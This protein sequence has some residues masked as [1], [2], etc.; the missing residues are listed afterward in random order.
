MSSETATF[1]PTSIHVTTLGRSRGLTSNQVHNCTHDQFG[2]LWLAGP[3][4]LN[5]FDGQSVQTIDATNGL[6]CQGLRHVHV[7]E[8]GFVW[9]GTDR[10]LECISVT[11]TPIELRYDFDW[12]FG[13]VQAICTQANT[14]WLGTANG[15]LELEFSTANRQLSLRQHHDIG[16]VKRVL[17]MSSQRLLVLSTGRGLLAITP[18][19]ALPVT[20]AKDIAPTSI[21]YCPDGRL[22]VGSMNGLLLFDPNLELITDLSDRVDHLETTAI[23]VYQNEWWIGHVDGMSVLREHDHK[24]HHVWQGSRVNHFCHDNLG[25]VYASTNSQGLKKI[26]FLRHYLQ[27]QNGMHGNAVYCLKSLLSPP[28]WVGGEGVL[29]R[30]DPHTF[31]IQPSPITAA[32]I[33]KAS[34]IWDIA[35]VPSDPDSVWFATQEGLFHLHAE[36]MRRVGAGASVLSSPCRVLLFQANRLWVGTLAGLA[37][38]EHDTITPMTC[39]DGS[40]LGYVYTMV[41]DRHGRI[42]VGT[43][44]KGLW[45]LDAMQLTPVHNFPLLSDANIYAIAFNRQ[46]DMAVI[47]DDQILISKDND[48]ISVLSR[49]PPVA[50]WSLMWLDDTRLLIGSSDG[51]VLIDT[52]TPEFPLRLNALMSSDDWEFTNTRTLWQD[53]K[54]IYFGISAGLFRLNKTFFQ[55]Q[56]PSPE[57]KVGSTRWQGIKPEYESA[58]YIVGTGKWSVDIQVYVP[59]FVDETKAKFRYRLIGFDRDW[60]SLTNNMSIRYSSLPPGEYVLQLQAWTPLTGFGAPVDALRLSVSAP[61]WTYGWA[62]TFAWLRSRYEHYI[63]ANHRN[64]KLISI[65]ESLEKEIREQTQFL[66]AANQ[67]LKTLNATLLNVQEELKEKNVRLE[68]LNKQKN[69]FIGIAA[70]DLRNPLSVILSYSKFLEHFAGNK[71]SEQ[72]KTFVQEIEKSSQFMLRLVDDMLDI[73]NIESGAVK[74]V[75]THCDVRLLIASQIE[76]NRILADKKHISIA[77]RLDDTLPPCYVDKEK[78]QQ[79]LN[80]LIGNAIKYSPT[81]TTVTVSATANENDLTLAIADQGPGIPEDEISLLFKEFSTASSKPTAGEKSTGLGLAIVKKIVEAHQGNIWLESKEGQGTTFFVQ[82]PVNLAPNR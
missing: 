67:Q 20:V 33:L 15:L 27:N 77:E 54:Y 69:E 31:A 28:F 72:E 7:G 26:S 45:R 42:W 66:H 2:R 30:V 51:L 4:G 43:L 64:R 3:T 50:G 21:G 55:Q 5:I 22:L 13:M 32:V 11:G 80:N 62:D 65:N 57:I 36:Q 68:Q 61:W 53:E 37:Y 47:Q 76:L 29:A 38:I 8:Q 34:T 9:V 60:S 14:L 48:L 82:I 24:Q 46:G 6:Q 58:T 75:L 1:G 39:P 71:L 74:L 23:G 19:Q 18:Q 78:I 79:L 40:S 56:F 63:I 70:H 73:S 25:N 12:T 52:D 16:F 81:E 59:W 41:E 44:G 35:E 49:I 17:P 10:G